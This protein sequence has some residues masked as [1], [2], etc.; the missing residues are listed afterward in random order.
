MNMVADPVLRLG[1]A[2]AG[3]MGPLVALGSMPP[4]QREAT[5]QGR[6]AAADIVAKPEAQ[7]SWEDLAQDPRPVCTLCWCFSMFGVRSYA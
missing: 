3:P 1:T 5:V 2:V 7:P 6:V 4:L